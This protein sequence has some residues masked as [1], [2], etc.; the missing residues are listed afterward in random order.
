MKLNYDAILFDFDGVIIDSMGIKTEA[1]RQMFAPYG[2]KIVNK[3]IEYHL[4]NGGI[5]RQKKF[6]HFYKNYISEDLSNDDLNELCNI[7]STLVLDKVLE[8]PWIPG[9]KEFLDA[10]Y[11]EN[12]F[13][14][15]S[16]IPQ[17]ELDFIVDK[18]GI[19]KYFKAVMG[20]P[21]TKV[22]NIRYVIEK[23][24]YDYTKSIYIGDTLGD[25]KDSQEAGINFLGLTTTPKFPEGVKTIRDFKRGLDAIQD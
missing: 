2:N 24:Y 23:N 18:R 25:M 22:E 10:H 11:N 1:F 6:R 13:Y 12:T 3:V 20:S 9:A 8:A 21:K 15:I 4:K 16:G 5:S 7:F 19:R 17:E 14:L